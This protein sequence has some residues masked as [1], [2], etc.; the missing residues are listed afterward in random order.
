[1]FPNKGC[2]NILKRICTKSL[3]RILL[4]GICRFGQ[5]L[6]DCDSSSAITIFLYQSWKFNPTFKGIH[7]GPEKMCAQFQGFINNHSSTEINS[8]CVFHGNF[9]QKSWLYLYWLGLVRISKVG[10]TRERV[11]KTVI[12]KCSR[13]WK[14]RCNSMYTCS[15]E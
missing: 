2:C 3:V 1:M 4:T 13:N 15:E 6:H 12:R 14:L 8:S 9:L 7:P 10:P 11:F 5:R